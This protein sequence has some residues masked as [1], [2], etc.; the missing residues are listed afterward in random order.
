ME[1][2]SWK[3]Q[4]FI[5]FPKEFEIDDINIQVGLNIFLCMTTSGMHRRL[6]EGRYLV[7]RLSFSFQHLVW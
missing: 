7:Y 1:R 6:F 4:N 5:F 2:S 3:P